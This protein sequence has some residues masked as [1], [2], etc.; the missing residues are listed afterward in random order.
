MS[1][2]VYIY[3]LYVYTHGFSLLEQKLAESSLEKFLKEDW[4]CFVDGKE[5]EYLHMLKILQYLLFL[6][7]LLTLYVFLRSI[8]EK[9]NCGTSWS[10]SM[11]F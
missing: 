6:C 11:R 10:I 8:K 4:V 3:I 7:Y 2:C 5:K 1:V 9:S